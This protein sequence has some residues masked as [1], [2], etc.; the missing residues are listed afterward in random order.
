[1]LPVLTAIESG[2]LVKATAMIAMAVVV[3]FLHLA[4]PAGRA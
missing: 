3:L 1:M 4:A 2:E